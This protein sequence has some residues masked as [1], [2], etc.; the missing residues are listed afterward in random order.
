MSDT[1]LSEWPN[2]KQNGTPNVGRHIWYPYY[3]GYSPIFVQKVLERANLSPAALVCDPWNGAGTTTQVAH[4]LGY[5]AAGFDLNPVMVVV[6]RARCVVPSQSAQL[7]RS[8]EKIVGRSQADQSTAAM[9]TDP[10]NLWLQPCATL[11]VRRVEKAIR[12]EFDLPIAKNQEKSKSC[13]V[14][15]EVAFFYTA[16]FRGLFR[17][18]KKFRTSNPTWLKIP[19]TSDGRLCFDTSDFTSIFETEVTQ[20]LSSLEEEQSLVGLS[21]RIPDVRLDVASSEAL[22]LQNRAANIV[23]TSPPYC[24]RID[25]AVATSLELAFLGFD[26]KVSVRKLR[27]RMI[28]TSTVRAILPDEDARWGLT[29]HT[30]LSQIRDHYSKASRSYYLKT[31][32]QYFY[33]IY[34]SLL[35]LNR[36]LCHAGDC[37]FVVQDSYYKDIHNDLASIIIE[38][39]ST[40]SW[41]VVE[42][43]DFPVRLI[44]GRVNPLSR[45]YR[46]SRDAVESMV[47]FKTPNF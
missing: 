25:Y 1:S 13:S 32:L 12:E 35:E 16:I 3:A 4:D 39:T 40:I 33:D 19:Q 31:H 17:L 18:S 2:P 10:L 46:A 26:Y 6:A 34:S 21:G 11:G 43:R 47:W 20:M 24:T 5:S 14:S 44:L 30:F 27:D 45:Y 42:R 22:P 15:R 8:L 7:R 36:V 23:I 37:I 41:R 28:G 29:C 38:M 9:Q